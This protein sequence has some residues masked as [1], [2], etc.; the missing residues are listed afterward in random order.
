MPL[1]VEIYNHRLK[2]WEEKEPALPGGPPVSFS[3]HTV[4][5][6]EELY[7]TKCEPDD[8]KSVIYRATGSGLQEIR[9][10]ADGED[11]EMTL[12]SDDMLAPAPVRFTHIKIDFGTRH[13]LLCEKEIPAPQFGLHIL[14]H[15]EDQLMQWPG[16]TGEM[17]NHLRR[18]TNESIKR[19]KAF[20]AVQHQLRL[21][22]KAYNHLDKRFKAPMN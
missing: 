6:G 18:S 13:C 14:D 2:R 4:I 7:A 12:M 20:P 17:V 1:K 3:N 10:L 15:P 16:G 21:S 9:R 8:E 5:G 22:L 11:F 19:A